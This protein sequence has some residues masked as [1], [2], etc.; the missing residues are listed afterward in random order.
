MAGLR[1]SASLIMGQAVV[2]EVQMYNKDPVSRLGSGT[3][4]VACTHTLS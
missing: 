3:A 1:G 2:T 4:L